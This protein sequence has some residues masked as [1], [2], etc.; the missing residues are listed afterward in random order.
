MRQL[1]GS[2]L[3]HQTNTRV[4][5]IWHNKLQW[6]LNQKAKLFIHEI[7]SA[8]IVCE[9]TSISPRGK[10]VNNPCY[11]GCHTLL[12]YTFP[13]DWW[14]HLRNRRRWNDSTGK[15]SDMHIIFIYQ[16]HQSCLQYD[17]VAL[18]DAISNNIDATDVHIIMQW[19]NL[20]HTS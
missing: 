2:T 5:S 8:N 4:M 16:I 20:G 3:V 17:H 19:Y 18:C 7:V 13:A 1:I 14:R 12:W 9:M 15:Y 6:N 11:C 10:W